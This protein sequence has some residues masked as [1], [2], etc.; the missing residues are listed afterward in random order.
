MNSSNS[1]KSITSPATTTFAG[2]EMHRVILHGIQI[3]K[4][5]TG[6]LSIRS[7]STIIGT[8]AA[9]VAAGSYWTSAHGVEIADLT[10]VNNLAEDVTV[11]YTNIG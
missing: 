11:F 8:I 4:A 5:L 10:I 7:G 3:N 2:N 1:F 6:T 9:S